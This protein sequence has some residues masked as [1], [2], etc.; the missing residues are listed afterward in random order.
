MHTAG[1]EWHQARQLSV[2]RLLCAVAIPSAIAYGGFHTVLPWLVANGTPAVIAWHL[3]AIVML[4]GLVG[5][6]LCLLRQEAQALSISLWNRMCLKP[7]TRKQWS[8]YTCVMVL[9]LLVSLTVQ[10]WTLVFMQALSLSVPSYMPFFLNP[11]LDP[12]TVDTTVLSPG[13]SLRGSYG[14]LPLMAFTLV[15]NIL[16][17]ELY[18]RAWMLPKLSRFGVWSWVVNGSMFALYH[19]FQIWLL[20]VLWVASLFFAFVVYSSK[21]LWPSLAAHLI[22]NLLFSLLGLVLLIAG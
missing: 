14:L 5:V 16:A 9:G 8:V 21:S 1:F 22:G 19:S 18:F 20:P 13:Y 15:L 11:T 10:P 12:Q 17:E 6:A 3:V 2:A 4:L 7:L